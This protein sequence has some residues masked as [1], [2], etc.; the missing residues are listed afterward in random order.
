MLKFLKLK[1]IIATFLLAI[2]CGI[3]GIFD[4]KM[5]EIF[6]QSSTDGTVN[7]VVTD[8]STGVSITGAT[9]SLE[10]NGVVVKNSTTLSDGSY[11][12]QGLLGDYIITVS[13]RNFNEFSQE[14]TFLLSETITLNVE[15]KPLQINNDINQTSKTI[16]LQNAV[17]KISDA[18]FGFVD[19]I[20]V[21]AVTGIDI[22]DA[23]VTL[24]SEG[25]IVLKITTSNSGA[26]FIQT[27]PGIYNITANKEGFVQNSSE[28]AI[29]AFKK[30]SQ[31]I[32][33][34]AEDAEVTP[35]PLISVTPIS[36]ASPTP[37]PTTIST[38]TPVPTETE[39]TLCEGG[40][41]PKRIKLSDN[42]VRI[43][44]G[45]SANVLIQVF[46]EQRLGCSTEVNIECIKG[47][48]MLDQLDDTTFTNNRGI[49]NVE[50]NTK[51]RTSGLV[52]VVFS[53]FDLEASF[54]III[55]K[56]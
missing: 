45:E 27:A 32:N 55:K 43:N 39:I 48:E 37:I 3:T 47:C 38:P 42:V 6:A 9:V 7:G 14:I 40:G 33:L 22:P 31:D 56:N 8:L 52:K 30:V 12:F 24:S 5:T 50:I 46:K 1:I 36:T 44:A 23:E 51:K 11:S 53:V 49:A 13:K 17:N 4:C 21:N 29:S 10:Q 26:Y 25:E 20:V 16:G 35:T 18:V 2:V 19:G 54:F 34:L 15:L 41:I 28:V